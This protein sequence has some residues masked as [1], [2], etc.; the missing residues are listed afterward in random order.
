MKTDGGMMKVQIYNSMGRQIQDF[1]PIMDQTVGLYTCGPTVYNFAHIGNLRTYI[2]EDLLRRTLEFAGYQVNHVMNITDVGH[3]TDDADDGEDKMVLSSKRTGDTVW[4]IASRYTEAFFA[5]TDALNI[6]RPSVSCKATDHI[7]DMIGLIRRLEA[8]GHT[9]LAG[10]NVYFSIDT[11]P[12]YGRMAGLNLDE[13]QSGA[14]I[15]IDTHKRNPKDFVLWFTNSKFEN[16]AMVWDSPWGRGY[17]GWHIECSAMSMKYLGDHFDIHCGGIDH[18]SVHHTNEIAQ[19]EAATG[20]TWVNYWVHGEFLLDETGKMAKSK[21]EFLT[22]DL[23]RKRG[24]EPLDYRYYCLGAHYR[25]QLV[26]SFEALV[27]A[28]NARRGLYGRLAED[29]RESGADPDQLVDMMAEWQLGAEAVKYLE[30]FEEFIGK[31][32]NMPRALSVAWQT[33]K[34][35]GLAPMDRLVLLDTMDKVF[36]LDMIEKARQRH[37]ED[38]TESPVS[39]I[40]SEMLSLI[41]ER[42]Q[43]RRERN[44]NRADEIRDILTRNGIFITDTP[45]GTVWKKSL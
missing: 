21:G 37:L 24:F 5:D 9:Y 38:S 18:I 43:A 29:I 22:I 1:I 17:P 40:G 33:V 45:D 19:S 39:E 42:E 2:F 26:F 7:D 31:D 32:L 41:Q 15:E 14:R 6:K 27:S 12:E 8:G 4:D 16:Q 13:L 30:A 36:G 28:Q 3:L 20:T 44:F 34:D 23:L 35:K 25:T 10:G 11:F